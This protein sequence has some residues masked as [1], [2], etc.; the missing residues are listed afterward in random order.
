MSKKLKTRQEF[1]EEYPTPAYVTNAWK[2]MH[3]LMSEYTM[4][5][6][7]NACRQARA[8]ADAAYDRYVKESESAEQQS[9]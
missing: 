4:G 3:S 6:W 5:Q 8:E 7:E 9:V 1:I 2:A